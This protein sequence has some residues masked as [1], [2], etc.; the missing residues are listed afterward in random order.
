MIKYLV[1][2]CVFSGSLFG[3]AHPHKMYVD[4]KEVNFFQDAY[5]IHTGDNTW[6]ESHTMHTDASGMFTFRDYIKKEDGCG[7]FMEYERK[8]KCPYCYHYWP[9]KTPCENPDCPSRYL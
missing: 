5:H 8:W 2:L 4:S 3:Y 6:I 7:R 9:M 1:C